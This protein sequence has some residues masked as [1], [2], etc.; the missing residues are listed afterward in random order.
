MNESK[1]IKIAIA[2]YGNVGKGTFMVMLER[3][4]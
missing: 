3:V 4:L 2:G 1:E